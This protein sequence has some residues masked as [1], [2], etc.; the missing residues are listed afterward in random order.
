MD[1]ASTPMADNA[2]GPNKRNPSMTRNPAATPSWSDV[3]V[4]KDASFLDDA[5][6]TNVVVAVYRCTS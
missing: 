3:D 2:C 4:T 6:A 5:D 1:A